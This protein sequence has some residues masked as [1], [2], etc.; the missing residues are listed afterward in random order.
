MERGG[1]TGDWT[2]EIGDELPPDDQTL[3]FKLQ[4]AGYRRGG[5][6]GMGNKWRIRMPHGIHLPEL[7]QSSAIPR[8]GI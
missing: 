6:I 5:L 7:H 2:D 8:F 3:D 1:V 4:P